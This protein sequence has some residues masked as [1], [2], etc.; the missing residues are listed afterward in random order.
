M[1]DSR[2][3]LRQSRLWAAGWGA[4]ILL[5]GCMLATAGCTATYP[6]NSTVTSDYVAVDTVEEVGTT[7]VPVFQD[8]RFLSTWRQHHLPLDAFDEEQMGEVVTKTVIRT[9]EA[10]RK[11][12]PSMT[13]YDAMRVYAFT[14]CRGTPGPDCEPERVTLFFST[15]SPAT[16]GWAPFEPSARRQFTLGDGT[17][18]V[19]EDRELAYENQQRN[20][21][22]LEKMWTTV[23][24]ETFSALVTSEEVRMTIG[25]EVLT[26]QDKTLR[27][28]RALVAAVQGEDEITA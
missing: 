15:V 5:V 26:F 25:R 18:T 28:L 16:G 24:Y 27:A 6:P 23:S 22:L 19:V 13:G 1:N 10:I 14:L 21:R 4:V 17:E 8:G 20:D 12:L 7:V 2:A 9:P 11:S 3:H